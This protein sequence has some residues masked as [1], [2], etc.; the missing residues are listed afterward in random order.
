MLE[1]LQ[2]MPVDERVKWLTALHDCG[3]L[4]VVDSVLTRIGG[5]E[6]RELAMHAIA[7]LS[8]SRNELADLKG[9]ND[10]LTP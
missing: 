1:Y 9:S 4:N 5:S 8:D 3:E 10:V 2:A 6:L 7:M